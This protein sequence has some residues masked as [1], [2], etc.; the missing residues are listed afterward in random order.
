MIPNSKLLHLRAQR[1]TYCYKENSPY[2]GVP[3]RS[4]SVCSQYSALH[5]TIDEL[6]ARLRVC[7]EG[8]DHLADYVTSEHKAYP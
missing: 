6:I 7:A 5:P 3:L 2:S 8:L 1:R 4:W